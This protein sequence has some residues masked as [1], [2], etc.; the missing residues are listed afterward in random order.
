MPCPGRADPGPEESGRQRPRQQCDLRTYDVY[1]D[2][3]KLDKTLL[4][5]NT[6]RNIALFWQTSPNISGNPSLLR[7][8]SYLRCLHLRFQG[9]D[10]E[11]KRL[12][13]VLNTSG[14]HLRTQDLSRLSIQMS[15]IVSRTTAACR[16]TPNPSTNIVPT[17]NAWLELSGKSPMDMR[18][19][20]L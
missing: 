6:Y 10:F 4:F 1:T 12:N 19:P 8:I 18:I 13:I 11:R 17:N 3:C 9:L 7:P 20:P 15:G 2:I 16:C 5:T 14:D